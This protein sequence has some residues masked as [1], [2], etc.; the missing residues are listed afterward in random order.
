MDF[1]NKGGTLQSVVTRLNGNGDP[2]IQDLTG[3][4]IPELAFVDFGVMRQLHIFMCNKDS[5]KIFSPTVD[6]SNG[7]LYSMNIEA[8]EDMNGDGL[9]D[10]ITSQRGCSGSGCFKISV[11]EWHGTDFIDT[12][13]NLSTVGLLEFSITDTNSDGLRDISL[14][15]GLFGGCCMPGEYPRRMYTDIY[16]WN[17]NIFEYSEARYDSPIFRFQALQDADQYTL[18]NEFDNALIL[19]QD[20]IFSDKLEWWSKQRSEFTTLSLQSSPPSWTDTTPPQIDPIPTDIKFEYSSL[21]AYAYY[22]IML[23]HTVRGYESDAGTVYNTLQQK[24]GADPNGRPYTEMATAFWD[25]YQSTHKLYD[26]CAA[27]I[28]YAAEHPEILIPLGSDYHG[29]QSHTYVPADV[30]PFR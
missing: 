21:A 14:H 17:G 25:A 12:A 27:A 15:G 3:D 6:S 28:Q 13:P 18:S 9:K 23:L 8:T 1:L 4:S 7:D 5:F 24:F 29:W 30:C 10:I 26:G 22:R 2:V 20:T 16:R 11:F 19:Y